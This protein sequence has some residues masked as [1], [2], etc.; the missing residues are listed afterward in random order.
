MGNERSKKVKKSNCNCLSLLPGDCAEKILGFTSPVDVCRFSLVSKSL[1]SAAVS[2]SVWEKFLPSDL[3]SIIATSLSPIPH[4]PLKKDLYVYL[5]HYPIL[6]DAGL[7]SFSLEK[8]TGK[9]CYFLGARDL[10]LPWS[11]VAQYWNWISRPDSRF[12]EVAKLNQVWVL[13]IQGT[14]RAGVLSPQTSYS[15]YL[16][17]KF[18]DV[19]GFY[20][21]PLVVSVGVSG[22]QLDQRITFMLPVERRP[23]QYY[24]IEDGNWESVYLPSYPQQLLHWQRRH[25]QGNDASLMQSFVQHPK[26][27]DD[28]WLEVELGEFFLL[29]MKMIA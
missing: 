28:G 22:F 10:N 4:F 2:D 9:K 13:D 18:E 19:Y 11:D 26:L 1:Q 12:P 17:Y 16:V 21:R 29:E 24:H 25:M 23:Q 15:A 3:Q 7:K 20:H 5:C 6:I 8:W 27:R 14:I